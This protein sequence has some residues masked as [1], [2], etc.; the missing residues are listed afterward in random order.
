MEKEELFSAKKEKKNNTITIDFINL[1]IYNLQIANNNYKEKGTFIDL[2]KYALDSNFDNFYIKLSTKKI[3]LKKFIQIIE[4]LDKIISSEKDIKYKKNMQFQE[5]KISKLVKMIIY[6]IKNNINTGKHLLNIKLFKCLILMIYW[7]IIPIKSLMII[8]NIFLSSN[9]NIIIKEKQIINKPSLFDDS[10]LNFINDLFEALT[11]VPRR[12]INEEIHIK[13]I[14]ELIQILEQILFTIPFNIELNKL[15]IWLKLLG[16]KI[17]SLDNKYSLIYRKIISFLVKIY[18]FNFQNVFYYKN[19]YEKS[20]ISFDYYIN[21]LDFLYALFKD[22]QEYRLIDNFKIKNGFYIY[23]NMPLTLDEIKISKISS[24]SLIFSFKLTKVCNINEETILFNLENF[25]KQKAVLRIIIN[26]KDRCLII[27]DSKNVEWNTNISIDLN[28]DY[29]ICLTQ[30]DK[31]ITGKK[32]IIF[33]NSE[34]EDNQKRYNNY[35]NNSLVLP[36]LEQNLKLELGKYNFEGIFGELILLNKIIKQEDINHLYNLKDNYADVICN[37][38][39]NYDLTYKSKIYTNNNEDIKYFQ[40]LKYQCILKILTKQFDSLLNN[41]NSIIVKPYGILKYSKDIKDNNIINADELNI[42]LYTRIYSIESF[43]NQHGLEYL[44][45]Q[46]HRII[47]LSEND[48]SLNYYLY[49]TLHFFL[50]YIKMAKDL[51]FPKKDH[52]IKIEKKYIIFALSLL[53]ILK[54]SNRQLQLDEKIMDILL[55]FSKFY[56]EI[57]VSL[58][59]QKLNYSIL[60]DKE[61]FKKGNFSFYDKLFNEM[62]LYKENNEKENYLFEKEI[63]LQFLLLDDILDSIE[64]KH[65]KYMKIISFFLIG[66]E[67]YK[68]SALKIFIQYIIELKNPKKL[69]HYLK[70]IYLNI[71]LIQQK[72][73]KDNIKFTN[74]ISQNTNVFNNNNKNKYDEYNQILCFLLNEIIK[75]NDKKR[76]ENFKNI[77]SINYKFIK[78][79]FIQNYN[80]N[81]ETKLNFIKSSFNKE[82][83]MDS[84]KQINDKKFNILSLLDYSNFI[85]KLNSLINYL[86]FIYNNEYLAKKNKDIEVLLKNSIKLIFDF[87]D[88][89]SN[90]QE[91][92]N[93]KTNTN[94]SADNII[95]KKGRH[96]LNDKKNKEYK[97]H[98]FINELFS[99]EGIKKIFILYF[100]LYELN[101]LKDFKYFSKYLYITFDK[102]YN[103]FY[104]YLLSPAIKLSNDIQNNNNYKSKMLHYIINIMISTKSNNLNEILVLNSIIIIIRIYH[105]ILDEQSLINSE[106]EKNIIDYLKYFFTYYFVYSKIIFDLDLDKI[107]KKKKENKLLLEIV[108]DIIF[109]LFEKNQNYELILF[110]KNNL[111]LKENNSIFFK[112][113]EFFLEDINNDINHSYKNIVINLLNNSNIIAKYCSGIN[114]S[115]IMICFYFLIYFIYKQDY[116]NSDFKNKYND[117]IKKEITDFIYKTLEIIFK[118]CIIIYNKYS[119]KKNK[120]KNKIT[121]DETKFKAYDSL[122][123]FFSK[124]KAENFDFSEG[125]KIYTHFS[126]FLKKINKEKRTS[127]ILKRSLSNLNDDDSSNKALKNNNKGEQHIG[128]GSKPEVKNFNKR[129]RS[130]S[131]NYSEKIFNNFNNKYNKE[132]TNLKNSKNYEINNDNKIEEVVSSENSC[133]TKNNALL[134]KYDTKEIE[135]NEIETN[136]IETNEID[137]TEIEANEL[138]VLRDKKNLNNEESYENS[139]DSDD[140][141]SLNVKSSFNSNI[142]K[143]NNSINIINEENVSKNEINFYLNKKNSSSS[144]SLQN[145]LLSSNN[146]PNKLIYN[147]ESVR[148]IDFKKTSN[149]LPIYLDNKIEDIDNYDEQKYLSDKLNKIDIPSKYYKKLLSNKDPKWAR[150][151]FNP[152]RNIFK[153]FGISF[154]NY[155]FNNRRFNKLKNLFKVYFKN[156]DLE[157]SIPE[158]ENYSLKYPSKLKNFTCSDYY[159]PFLKPMLNFFENDYFMNAHSF[160]KNKIFL[161]DLKEE[162]KFCKIKYEKLIL[163]SLNEKDSKDVLKTRCENI[164]NKGSIFGSIYCFN[165]L[166]AFEDQS[167]KDERLS[168]DISEQY[169]LFF[170]FSSDT[171][172]RLKNTNK[173]III[174]YSEIKEIILRKYCFNEI[175]YEIFMKDGR[176]YFFNFFSKIN[177]DKF[178][179]NLIVKINSVNSNL[180]KEKIKEHDVSRKIKYDFNYVNIQFIEHPK[181]FFEKNEYSKKYTK[182]EISNFQYLLLVN[183]FSYRTYNDCNQYLIFPLLY[184]DINKKRE[185]NLSKAICLNKDLKEEDLLKF[186]NNFETMGYHFNSHY[187]TMAYVLYYLMR[188]IPFTFSQIKLQSGHFDAPARMFSSLENLLF[189]FSVSDENRELCPELFYSYESFLNLNYNDF[190]YIK[191]SKKQ[192]NHFRTNQNCGIVEFIIDLRKI[193]EKK[194]LSGWI[195]NIFGSNQLSETYDSLNKYPEYSYEKYNNFIKEKETLMVEAEDD[196]MKDQSF[197]EAINNR[198]N[199]LRGRIQMLSLGLTPTQLFKSPHPL[200]EKIAKKQNNNIS[201]NEISFESNNNK[202]GK[203]LKKRKSSIYWDDKHLID[204]L[205]QTSSTD[206]LMIFDNED[207]N[208]LKII[209]ISEKEIKIFQFLSEN[210]KDIRCKNITLEDELKILDI[211]PYKNIFVELYYNVFLICRFDNR[212]L[213]LSNKSEKMSIEW[214][215]IVTAIEFYSHD[216]IIINSNNEIHINRIIMGDEDG[217]LSLIEIETE[218]NE[219]KKEF[220]MNSLSF[221]HKKYKTFY[222]FINRIIY[223]KRLN[224]IISSSNEGII[225]INNGFS[226]EILNIIEIDNNPNILEFKLSEYDL[227]YLYTKTNFNEKCSYQLLCYTLNGL[228]ISELKNEKEF[229]NYFINNNEINAISK[230]GNIYEYNI[231]N[232]KEIESKLDKEDIDDIKDKGD[233]LYCLYISKLQKIFIIF[234]KGIKLIKMDK[235]L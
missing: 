34:S 103:P 228:K 139:D 198:I 8:I 79:L 19:F 232:L 160:I 144:T 177:R 9:I 20:A 178:Y 175:A 235:N 94:L 4:Y 182:N 181:T 100:N 202:K 148:K 56:R 24:Y 11:N 47:S 173:Y 45:F 71:N 135:T 176:S 36:N 126:I 150:I 68:N 184:M 191:I 116:F 12:F 76:F 172:D 219:K 199:D 186:K 54:K 35:L 209:F 88:E 62:I 163:S 15:T 112:I 230:G 28:K 31:F 2:Q 216:E 131:Q 90:R 192:I 97:I 49:K 23:N 227:L 149:C 22:E 70:F 158:E 125:G 51:I 195:N 225:S 110:L 224:I 132:A 212:T 164:S 159:K 143:N 156:V 129:L 18:K 25:E 161:N 60:L 140:Y 201:L 197:K 85:N 187:S 69:Y 154:R 151:I 213:L 30:E 14:D 217:N 153:I 1:S 73:I 122:I 63:L 185:R 130:S 61:I 205:N 109:K 102:I 120:N 87:L 214:S 189:V 207:N 86:D 44:I 57:K 92:K 203:F 113:D 95:K 6:M 41:S 5:E 215:C 75:N 37:I 223:N 226:F 82:N 7:E 107:G 157:R 80:I 96:D 38:N 234:N 180:Q 111:K 16:N 77:E 194:E 134:E 211:K 115:N 229:I 128:K 121:N 81:N 118:N 66:K 91:L 146:N 170:I 168:P 123:E 72:I 138:S 48:V 21:S 193:L 152:K 174:Y 169:K 40:N 133:D 233:V 145:N 183:K 58:N 43:F 27:L 67:K 196:K 200:K 166:M 10:P 17:I 108:L 204:F 137:T 231:A 221:I 220:K 3:F 53:T 13:F 50:E 119:K 78:C 93:I 29:L 89:I 84:L 32:S 99:S 206:K 147:E 33:I 208:H 52:K 26:N 136:E 101:E 83:E 171:I 65:K 210:E 162:D 155:I 98:N 165:S 104:F 106:L 64:I 39:S 142:I 74:F 222:S 46:L 190:G 218:F 179:D 59:L 188:L 55:D 114:I 124:Y 167:N 105:I 117:K 141:N 127:F 42:R